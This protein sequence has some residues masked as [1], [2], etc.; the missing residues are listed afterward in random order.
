[1]INAAHLVSG[2]QQ[3]VAA[4]LE[5]RIAADQPATETAGGR[6]ERLLEARASSLDARVSPLE[7]M[8]DGL[9]SNGRLQPIG[10]SG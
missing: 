9:C 3:D 6:Q 7:S 4:L 2:A 10:A 8:R 5:Q 1:V